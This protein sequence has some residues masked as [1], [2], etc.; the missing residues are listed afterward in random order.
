MALEG[1]KKFQE[2]ASKFV[3]APRT[4]SSKTAHGWFTFVTWFAFLTATGF[5]AS[6]LTPFMSKTQAFW[7][8]FGFPVFFGF[9]VP[10]WVMGHKQSRPFERWLWFL[11]FG[12]GAGFLLFAWFAFAGGTFLFFPFGVIMLWGLVLVKVWQFISRKWGNDTISSR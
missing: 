11:F 12:L 5:L 9:F 10:Q 8:A 3:S 6:F 2:I 7:F 1:G 4:L